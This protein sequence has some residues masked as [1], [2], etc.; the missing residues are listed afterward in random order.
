MC[1][2]F[3]NH[4]SADGHL[5][6]FLFLATVNRATITMDVQVSLWSEADA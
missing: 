4:S 6:L 1:P 3:I 2:V 5:G